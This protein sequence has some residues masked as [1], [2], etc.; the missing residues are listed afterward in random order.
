MAVSRGRNVFVLSRKYVWYSV[1]VR[2][3]AGAPVRMCDYTVIT[4]FYDEAYCHLHRGI[5]KKY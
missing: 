1:C 2:A 3:R 5:M 4:R